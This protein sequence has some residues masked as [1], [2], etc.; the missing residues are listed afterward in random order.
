MLSFPLP[1]NRLPLNSWMLRQ[2]VYWWDVPISWSPGSKAHLIQNKNLCPA[3][4]TQLRQDGCC[5]RYIVGP[6]PAGTIVPDA[7]DQFTFKQTGDI[8]MTWHGSLE[9]PR[10]RC[11]RGCD[12]QGVWSSLQ[13]VKTPRSKKPGVPR[14]IHCWMKAAALLTSRSQVKQISDKKFPGKPCLKNPSFLGVA[15]N[16]DRWNQEAGGPDHTVHH[17]KLSSAGKALSTPYYFHNSN[18]GPDHQFLLD[19]CVGTAGGDRGRYGAD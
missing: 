14:N 1:G 3:Q 19:T 10:K 7:L 16:P 4:S 17:R 2:M 6:P 9:V 8:L 5:C 11:F 18:H 12:L 15:G 13:E